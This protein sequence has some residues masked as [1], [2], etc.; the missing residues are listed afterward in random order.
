MFNV[1]TA[2]ADAAAETA[3]CSEGE[4]MLT[5]SGNAYTGNGT[6]K[7]KVSS[8]NLRTLTTT[9]LKMIAHTLSLSTS[10]PADEL[11]QHIDGKLRAM[12]KKPRNVQVL[13]MWT[14]HGGEYP[15]L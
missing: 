15:V 14:E 2:T 8:L 5:E 1:D 3:E 10:K 7:S 9:L 6:V 13:A 12:G 4:Q 11:Q